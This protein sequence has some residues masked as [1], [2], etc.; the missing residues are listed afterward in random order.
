MLVDS[1]RSV[2]ENAAVGSA[3]GAP[4]VATDP[5][6]GALTYTLSGGDGSFSIDAGDGQLRVAGSLAPGDGGARGATVRR[7]SCCAARS[8]H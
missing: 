4:L 5:E 3:V 1:S 6:G 7:G 2:G 8:L